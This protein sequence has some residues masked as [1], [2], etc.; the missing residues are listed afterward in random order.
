[1][2]LLEV[3]SEWDSVSRSNHY[4]ETVHLQNCIV[5][6]SFFLGRISLQAT[7]LYKQE[8]RSAPTSYK[9]GIIE[10]IL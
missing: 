9:A 8:N 1:M 10:K 7:H 4:V 5:V 6:S 2:T 3:E